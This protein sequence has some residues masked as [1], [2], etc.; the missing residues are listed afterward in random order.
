MAEGTICP[1]CDYVR[2]VEEAVP[3]WQCPS[4]QVVYAKFQP[5][6]ELAGGAVMCQ[7]E[8]VAVHSNDRQLQNLRASQNL[9]YGIAAGAGA[10][11]V[12]AVL[13]AVISAITKYQIGWMAIGVG[14][15]VGYAVRLAGKGVDNS[16]G[17]AGAMLSF[18]GCVIG[19]FLTVVI[20]I[21]NQESMS[22]L[23]I[24]SRVTPGIFMAVMK[25]SFQAMD[26]LFYGFAV[27]EGYKF[28]MIRQE[29][30]AERT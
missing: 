15:L 16:F 26:L 29:E 7:Q 14:V 6:V 11:L 24:L 12:G 22:I 28:S 27:Y 21:S 13:W 20:V 23:E 2:K 25:D 3:D 18:L 9:M 10:A 17:I 5:A 1:K 30:Q 8:P 19:N 4:C